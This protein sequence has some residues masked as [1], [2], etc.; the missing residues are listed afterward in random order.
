MYVKLYI[1]GFHTYPLPDAGLPEELEVEDQ[2]RDATA[3]SGLLSLCRLDT[4]HVELQKKHDITF[5]HCHCI[6]QIIH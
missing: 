3:G 2:D 4:L 6:L 1:N 5:A